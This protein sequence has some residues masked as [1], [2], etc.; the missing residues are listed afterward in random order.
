MD[1]P[2]F[3]NSNYG[4]IGSIDRPDL[5]EKFKHSFLYF[6]DAIDKERLNYISLIICQRFL[7]NEYKNIKKLKC[8]LRTAQVNWTQVKNNKNIQEKIPQTSKPINYKIIQRHLIRNKSYNHKELNLPELISFWMDRSINAAMNFY[9]KN[10]T[11]EV[12]LIDGL[13]K[14]QYGNAFPL[15]PKLNQEGFLITSFLELITKRISYGR[16]FLVKN[17]HLFFTSD[18]LFTLKNILNDTISLVDIS[19]NQLHLKASYDKKSEWQFNID[20]IRKRNGVRLIDKLKWVKIITGNDLNIEKEKLSLNK[21]KEI[22]N[23]LNHFDPPSFVAT[24]NEISDWLNEIFKVVK[25]VMTIRFCARETIN[26][27]LIEL[28]LQP[29]IYFKPYASR[30]S[31]INNKDFG[32]NSVRYFEKLNCD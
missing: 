18:W 21:L 9:C 17:S 29:D 7:G 5:F 10:E 2:L 3:I 30:S 32:Y 11:G 13:L 19:L 27:D 8:D 24:I 23:H 31:E 4:V 25:I 22:R 15:N 14:Q 16:V 6:K 28:Y 20:D 1:D 12:T 26:N